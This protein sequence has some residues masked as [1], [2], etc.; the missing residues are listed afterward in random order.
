[1]FFAIEIVLYGLSAVVSGILNAERDYFWSNAAPI[2]NNVVCTASFFAYA[3]LSSSNPGLAMLILAIGN[4]AGVAMQ[5]VVQLPAMRRHGVHLT[6]HID[7]HDHLLKETLIIGAPTL[8]ATVVSFATCSVQSTAA[9]AVTD[10]GAS[11]AYYARLWYTLP[12]AIIAVPITTAMFTE[13]STMVSKHD[14]R[15]F[16]S[17]ISSGISQIL[18]FLIP[19]SIFLAVFSDSLISLLAFGKFDTAE[20]GTTAS[21]LGALALSLPLYG[22]CTYLQKVC[23][24]LRRM[25]IYAAASVVAG[26]IQIVV[27]LAA[28]PVF[29]LNIVAY[30]SAAF[31]L[32]VD[33]V[34][35]VSLRKELGHIGMR[36]IIGTGLKA[37]GLGIVGGIVGM[38]VSAL[39]AGFLPDDVPNLVAA[40][41]SII[42]GGIPAVLVT[43]GLA[44]ALHMPEARSIRTMVA[45]VLHR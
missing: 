30:S 1:R 6:L 9:L 27:C 22:V 32:A 25:G 29:G 4:P 42:G 2:I 17:G 19:F 16:V 35:L 44:T 24:S 5:V 7:W 37:L 12:Y 45:R 21:Y 26:V 31:F 38:L 43:F 40:L 18:F 23:S 11:I 14:H 41:S 20:I 10:Q 15:G 34:T 39:I 8:I 33:A 13:L 3:A 28:A 36:G